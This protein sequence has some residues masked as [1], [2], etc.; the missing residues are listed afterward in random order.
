MIWFSHIIDVIS[1]VFII[2]KRKYYSTTLLTKLNHILCYYKQ[3]HNLSYWDCF[4][5]KYFFDLIE[6]LYPY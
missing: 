6:K 3:F 4:C 5:N 2:H 1:T